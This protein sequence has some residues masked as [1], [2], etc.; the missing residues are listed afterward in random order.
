LARELD[1]SIPQDLSLVVI[2][3]SR[4]FE[5]L[6]PP[7]TAVRQPHFEIG[8]A[9]AKRLLQRLDGDTSPAQSSW[10]RPELIERGSVRTLS[11]E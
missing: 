7:V 5:I 3:D 9:A 4:T 6:D 1:L 10:L 2:N 8:E 11:E